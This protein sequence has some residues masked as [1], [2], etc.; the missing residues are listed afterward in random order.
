MTIKSTTM[1]TLPRCEAV[2]PMES[3]HRIGCGSSERKTD[4]LV[5]IAA[6]VLSMLPSHH[7]IPLDWSLAI[8]LCLAVVYS[9]LSVFF[10]SVRVR[11]VSV[12]QAPPDALLANLFVETLLI[13]ADATAS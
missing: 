13:Q 9:C 5:E 8:D 10:V 6:L 12:T 1:H 4:A 7:P 3:K 2:V 11:S